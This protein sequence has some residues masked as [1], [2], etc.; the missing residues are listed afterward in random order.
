M[1]T[2]VALVIMLC[3]F[4]LIN[5]CLYLLASACRYP[6]LQHHTNYTQVD[7]K[8]RSKYT[9]YEI[10]SVTWAYLC[11]RDSIESSPVFKSSHLYS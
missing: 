5:S 11:V 3:C 8:S 7:T 6:W 4:C 10:R 1:L 2:H 9:L